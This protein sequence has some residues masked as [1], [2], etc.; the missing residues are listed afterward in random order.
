MLAIRLLGQ[1]QVLSAGQ[2]LSLTRRK[3]RAVLYYLAAH[4]QPV[5]RRQ[6]LALL[7]PDHSATTAR[8]NLRT[9]LYSLRQAL[10]DDLQMDNEWLALADGVD[11][12]ARGF[13]AGLSSP[14]ADNARLAAALARY[15]GDF[16]ADFDL[17]DAQ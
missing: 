17:P 15:Q 14:Q 3:S 4:P 8:H 6:L 2:P 1:T 13:V 11:V 12:D 10:G 5:A 16:L 9:T 7:W